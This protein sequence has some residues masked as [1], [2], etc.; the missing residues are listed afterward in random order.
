M[1]DSKFSFDGKQWHHH[2]QHTDAGF[3]AALLHRFGFDLLD[4]DAFVTSMHPGPHLDE[5]QRFRR[6]AWE[7]Y[8]TNN[9][10]ALKISVDLMD[11]VKGLFAVAIDGSKFNWRQAE[12]GFRAHKEDEVKHRQWRTWQEMKI[13]E[14][15]SFAGKSKQDQARILKAT[16]GIDDDVP[17]IAKRLAPLPKSIKVKP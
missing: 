3:G 5:L 8:E 9:S 13:R 4:F 11:V 16:H 10:L 2:E 7:A 12:N 17:T 14:S 15:P 6:N 1:E